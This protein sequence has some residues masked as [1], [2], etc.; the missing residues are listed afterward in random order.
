MSET[1]EWV[2]GE[3][4]EVADGVFRLVAQPASVNIGLVV[5][6]EAALL[7]DTGSSP[8][9]GARIRDAVARLTDRPLATVVVTHDHF[10]HAFGLGGFAG[11]RTVGHESLAETLSAPEVADGARELGFDPDLLAVPETLIAVADAV[12]LGAGRVAEVAH[13]GVGHSHGDLI[14]NIA[15]PGADGFPGVIFAGDLIESAGPPYFGPDS[16]VD[17]WS[18]TLDR[19]YNLARPGVIIVPGHGDPVDR[20]LVREQRDA[21]D[22][23]RVEFERLQAEGVPEDEALARGNWPFP[24]QHIAGVVGAAY[25]ELRARAERQPGAGDRPTLPLA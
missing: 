12:E 13:L 4:Q 5:G 1:R 20:E 24:A 10:D 16:S 25:A 22:A 7:I 19:L 18:W 9:Q 11:V 3:W 6:P 17:E 23:V 8:A 21:V 2:V 14:V 15:D